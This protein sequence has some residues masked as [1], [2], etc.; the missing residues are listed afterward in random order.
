MEGLN[1]TLGIVIP[2][3]NGEKYIAEMLDSILNQSFHDWQLFVIDDRS[4]D[5]SS[6]ILESF[7]KIDSRIHYRVRHVLPKG[8]Q[9]CRNIGFDLTAGAKYVVFFDNDD[10]L[11]PHCLEQRVKYMEAHKELDFA[12]FPAVTFEDIP[13]AETPR[14]VSGVHYQEDILQA[15]LNLTLPMIGWT[16]IY[17]RQSYIAKELKWDTNLLSLQDSFFNIQSILKG[18][19]FDFAYQNDKGIRPDYYYR[20][21]LSRNSVASKINSKEHFS[22]HLYYFENIIR[23]F[24]KEMRR[25]YK[26]DL[27]G[28]QYR[29]IL[30]FINYADKESIKK[31][32]IASL[33]SNQILSFVLYFVWILSGGKVRVIL[34]LFRNTAK[35]NKKIDNLWEQFM[36]SM[37]ESFRNEYRKNLDTRPSLV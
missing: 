23:S 34:Y 2:N 30:K 11:A 33:A 31:I 4:T 10:L 6:V 32:L 3:W 8:A 1:Y 19:K 18:C 36:H 13:F 16:N 29:F 12:I 35:R 26:K 22:S 15:M 37:A 21:P 27:Y 24:P 20:V 28:L 14:C 9:T 17:R 5:S 25:K 7:C